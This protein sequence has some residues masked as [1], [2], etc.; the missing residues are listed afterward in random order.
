MATFVYLSNDPSDLSG[1]LKA[2]INE[3]SPN[4]STTVSTAVTNTATVTSTTIPMTLTAGGTAAKWIT[5]PF[6]SAV[7]ISG[8][9]TSNIWGLESNA[10]ANAQIGL[11]LSQYTTSLQSAF[12]TTSLG[13]EISTTVERVIWTS[14]NGA[15]AN[16]KE[17]I[18]STAFSAGDRLAI[19]P[20]LAAFGVMA[21]GHT[22]TM[23][24]NGLTGGADGETWIQFNETFN[25]GQAQVGS[26][27]APGITGKGVSY[28]YDLA[29]TVQNGANEGLY[30]LNATAQTIIDEANNQADLS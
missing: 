18:T 5:V 2:Y 28:F 25:P 8:R 24:Y 20:V 21:T 22:V 4:A 6:D 15:S 29:N 1:Y 9:M 23:D 14:S 12:V 26:G 19:V 13:G 27:D 30:A 10:S 11:G 17:I 3:K 16:S 7:T